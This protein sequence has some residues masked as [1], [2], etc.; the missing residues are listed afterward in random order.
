MKRSINLKG[1]NLKFVREP[2]LEFLQGD[3]IVHLD[4]KETVYST[5]TVTTAL[6]QLIADRF[7]KL[8]DSLYQLAAI[9]GRRPI[10]RNR[11]A[12]GMFMKD[13]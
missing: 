8:S 6:Q 5:K 12:R 11:N 2:V 10:R 3:V 7:I 13:S 4:G 9:M 1:K